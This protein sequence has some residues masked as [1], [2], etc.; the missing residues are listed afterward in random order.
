[1]ADGLDYFMRVSRDNHQKVGVFISSMSLHV[2]VRGLCEAD[3]CFSFPFACCFIDLELL[4][5]RYSTSDFASQ[6][7]LSSEPSQRSSL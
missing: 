7:V 6:L 3:G 1:M 2:R 5:H 4:V